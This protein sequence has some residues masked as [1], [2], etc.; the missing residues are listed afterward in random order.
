MDDLINKLDKF[1]HIQRKLWMWGD[2]ECRKYLESL[3]ITDRPN[4]KGFPF[5]ITLVI[6]T[7]TEL[8]DE[9]YPQFKPIESIWSSYE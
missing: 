3:A 4:R 8:H 2:R 5:E 6:Q 1:P 7:L 9:Q